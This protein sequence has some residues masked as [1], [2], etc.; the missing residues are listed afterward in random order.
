MPLFPYSPAA[1]SVQLPRRHLRAMLRF[2]R[3]VHA[4]SRQPGYIDRVTRELPET[5]RYDPGH[6]SVMMGYDFHLTPDGPRLIEINTNAGGILLAYAAQH[7]GSPAFHPHPPLETLLRSGPVTRFLD[8]FATEMGLWQGSAPAKPERMVILDEHPPGQ[9]LYR[10]MCLLAELF[11]YWGVETG[12]VDPGELTMSEQGVFWDGKPVAMVYNRHCDFYLA[13]SPLAGL[14]TAYRAGRVCL[15][16][17]PRTYALL[18]DKR[19]MILM[20]DATALASAGVDDP[21]IRLLTEV[22]PTTRLLAEVDLE[23]I[24]RERKAWVLKPVSASG[25][26]GVLTGEKMSRKRFLEQEPGTTLVQRLVPPSLTPVPGEEKPMKTD[27]RLFAYQDRILGVAARLYRGQ[28][29]NFQMP[30]SGYGP[31]RIVGD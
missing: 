6:A 25:S 28:V 1:T 20:S 10:E 7:P 18:A 3:A 17:N 2:V 22:V 27:L 14:A 19:R 16:P 26:K 11:R 31:V 12:I 30:G 8:S 24:W 21:T 29:T 9:Y 13:G 15:T 4:L 23:M 5:A